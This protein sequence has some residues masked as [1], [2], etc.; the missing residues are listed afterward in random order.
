MPNSHVHPTFQPILEAIGPKQDQRPIAERLAALGY[1]HRSGT[2]HSF[3]EIY[4]LATG[5]VVGQFDAFD[6]VAFCRQAEERE[7]FNR[8]ELA[9]QMDA[10][11]AGVEVA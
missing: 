10:A 5:E 8:Q 9:Y 1:A 11:R 4:S 2:I 7:E 3:R 6:A